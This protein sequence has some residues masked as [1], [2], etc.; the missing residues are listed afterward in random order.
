VEVDIDVGGPDAHVKAV[1]L[2][3]A[4]PGKRADV[5]TDGECGNANETDEV[6]Q[7]ALRQECRRERAGGSVTR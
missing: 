3:Y 1:F 6:R 2:E 7:G 4:E 5:L